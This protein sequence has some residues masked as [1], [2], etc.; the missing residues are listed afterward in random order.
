MTKRGH[1]EVEFDFD[2]D[3]CY[4]FAESA[5]AQGLAKYLVSNI[6]KAK[7]VSGKLSHALTKE[8]KNPDDSTRTAQVERIKQPLH[9]IDAL[10]QEAERLV[11]QD[12]R[13]T[14]R[15]LDKQHKHKK[16]KHSKKA[17]KAKLN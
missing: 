10:L 2:C 1:S 16:S 5:R 3:H 12:L 7:E 11:F 9:E 8:L 14:S 4:F 6:R 15:D 17:K 13:Y